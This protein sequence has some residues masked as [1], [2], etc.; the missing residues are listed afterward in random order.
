MTIQKI[1]Q[2]DRI[3]TQLIH[4]GFSL[5]DSQKAIAACTST[6]TLQHILDILLQNTQH[7]ASSPEQQVP[8][9]SNGLKNEVYD[10]LSLK[11]TK[12]QEKKGRQEKRIP[13]S[14]KERK[15]GNLY[16]NRGQF[17][18]AELSYSLAMATLPAGH[19]RLVLLC[20]NRAATR[21]KLGQ[22][23]DCLDDC[24]TAIQLASRNMQSQAE[25]IEGVGSWKSQWLKALYRKACAL[26]GLKLY[27]AAIHVYEEYAKVDGTRRP[28]V[29]QGIARCQQAKKESMSN[30]ETSEKPTSFS[31]KIIPKKEQQ[32]SLNKDEIQISK[33]VREMREREKKKEAEEVERLEK[34]DKVN[35]QL[36]MWKTGKERNLRALL[37]SLELILWS[38]IQWKGVT[39]NELLEPRK[40]KMMYMKAISKVHP[41][42]LSSKATVE[43]KL[44]ASGIFTTLNQAYDTFRTDNNL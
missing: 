1:A 29:I 34:E 3:L 38:G 37:G 28:I 12:I 2:N 33:S 31:D 32:E 21:L 16:F 26:E 18:D 44:L 6:I 36:I 15:E 25:L 39:I 42:K 7:K 4:M 24:S 35:A 20:N 41:D 17:D 8:L 13:E 22:Y 43:Q 23:R 5:D 11:N 19:N 30:K 27:E 9:E 10:T 14:E 40:C